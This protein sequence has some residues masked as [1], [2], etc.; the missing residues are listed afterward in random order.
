MIQC[1]LARKVLQISTSYSVVSWR[2]MSPADSWRLQV[3]LGRLTNHQLYVQ[4]FCASLLL[5][6][7]RP[8]I[9]EELFAELV[10]HDSFILVGPNKNITRLQT[11]LFTIFVFFYSSMLAL[12]KNS[13]CHEVA[14]V[15]YSSFSSCL[16]P[17]G[18]FRWMTASFPY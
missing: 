3:N 5:L 10:V 14:L 15:S 7:I 4:S 13:C 18:D 17:A 16:C 8:K 12:W 6:N 11:W 2:L 1:P 9:P